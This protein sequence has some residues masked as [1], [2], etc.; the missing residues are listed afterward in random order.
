MA[1]FYID[2][3]NY[4]LG[5][6]MLKGLRVNQTTW[7]HLESWVITALFCICEVSR[8]ACYWVHG[9]PVEPVYILLHVKLPPTSSTACWCHIMQI[10]TGS[11][12]QGRT[13]RCKQ[14]Y[15]HAQLY[16][17]STQKGV[18]AS[19]EDTKV[20]PMVVFVGI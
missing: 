4:G 16:H 3:N 12:P 5:W 1:F 11:K 2:E 6:N 14:M 18:R 7:L 9:P 8:S 19:T 20:M 15:V 17:T 10:H 13:S